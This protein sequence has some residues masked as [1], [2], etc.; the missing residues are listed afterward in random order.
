[1]ER[2]AQNEL[3]RS[4]HSSRRRILLLDYEGTLV[5]ENKTDA[6]N[7]EVNDLLA[8]LSDDSHNSVV[9]LSDWPAADL[10]N[11][12]KEP[13]ITVTAE[14]GGFLKAPGGPWQQLGDFYLLWKQPVSTALHRLARSYPNTAI[15]EKQFSIRWDYGN[16]IAHL[17]ESDQRQLKA[18]FRIMSGQYN[19]PMIETHGSVEFRA[20]GINKAKF[21]ASWMNLHGP[22]DFILAMGDNKSDEGVFNL[23]GH[24]Y[25]TVR[26]GF[27][28]TSVARYYLQSRAEVLPLLK[29]LTIA[30]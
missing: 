28:S 5:D 9:V 21:V 14:S 4:Y 30:T 25:F 7:S 13:R 16:G 2:L 26:V 10:N 8:K 1:M 20:A 22:C 29:V 11:R 17:P 6:Y 24:K 23:V 19:V 12:I 3:L 18:A 15:E 27:D